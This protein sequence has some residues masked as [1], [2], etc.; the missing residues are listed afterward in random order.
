MRRKEK[1]GEGLKVGM[2]TPDVSG[3][4]PEARPQW[5]VHGGWRRGGRAKAE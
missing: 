3:G 2:G 1:R 4:G 5:N